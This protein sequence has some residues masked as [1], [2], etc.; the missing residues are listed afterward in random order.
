VAPY[1]PAGQGS[2]APPAQYAPTGHTVQE[3]VRM[4]LPIKSTSDS[5]VA[6]AVE[7]STFTLE[8]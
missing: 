6:F 2:V 1:T 8:A 7:A 4:E 5:V 3:A